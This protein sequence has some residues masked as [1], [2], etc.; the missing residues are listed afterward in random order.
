MRKSHLF[1]ATA[2]GLVMGLAAG[3]VQAETVINTATTTA[4]KTSTA[5]ST[6]TAD[7]I[8]LDTGGTITLKTAGARAI[9]VD[10]NNKVNVVGAI[11][12]SSSGDDATGIY[13][14]GGR[15][16]GLTLS[17]KITVT[18]DY[19][20]TDTDSPADGITDGPFAKG[21]R[22]YGIR[23]VGTTPFVGNVSLASGS[24]IQVEGNNSYGVRFE[25]ALTGNFNSDS[26]VTVVGTN[27][28]AYSFEGGVTGNIVI[29][30]AT[31]V[32]GE[33]ATALNLGSNLTGALI[34]DGSIAG[35]GYR[36]TTVADKTT[37][38]KLQAEDKLQAGPLVNISGNVTKGILLQSTIANTDSTKPAA[39]QNNDEDG[40]GVLD[41]DDGA[42]SLSQYGGA[43]ALKVGSA[44]QDITINA[45]SIASTATD[46]YKNQTFG[47]VVRGNIASS[48]VFEGVVAKAIETG[49]LGRTVTFE[50]G[51]LVN[52]TVSA[53]SYLAGVRT[54]NLLSGT[55]ANK[56][57]VGGTVRAAN[58]STKNETGYAVYIA[59]GA[60][61][62]EINVSGTVSA[63]ATGSKSNAT[64]IFD[65]SNTLVRLT[66]TGSISATLT[67]TDDDGDGVVDATSNRAV[68]IDLS[69]NTA[70]VTLTQTNLKPDDATAV[71]PVIT[72]DIRLGS[73]NDA[74]NINGGFVVGN[75]DFGAG[76]NSLSITT[77]GIVAGKMT[78]AG[79]VSIDIV[80]GA[81]NLDAG[82]KL[83]ATTVNV[84]KDGVLR[85][86]PD[87]ANPTTPIIVASGA[88]VFDTGAKV[89]IGMSSIVKPTTRYTLITASNITLG[90]LDTASLDSNIP[91]LYK[92][93]LST[94]TG[95][96]ALYADVRLRT[97]SET[98]LSPN[99]FAAF[100]A[101]LT[102]A[103]GNTGATRAL[104]DPTSADGFNKAYLSFLPDYSGETLLTLSKSND[105][106]SR[107]MASQSI[108]P[109][110]GVNQYWAQEYG[111]Q[112]N[113]DRGEATGFDST[114]FAFAGGVER[115]ITSTQAAGLYLAYTAA[116][117]KGTLGAPDEDLSSTD[118]S[119]GLYWRMDTGSG[120]KSWVR[121][122]VGYAHFDSKRQILEPS[123]IASSTAKWKGVSYSGSVGA[124]YS[125]DAGWLSLTPMVSADYY[126]LKEDAH[127]E[128]G[129]GTAFDL[130]VDE[131][132]GHIFSGTA[133]LNIGRSNKTALF[134][135]EV[136]VG[137]R[138]N[139][140][141]EIADT[142][143]RFGTATPFTLKGGDIKGGAPIAGVRIAASN[144]YSYFGI[145]AEYEKYDAYDNVSLSLRA[146]FQF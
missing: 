15:T 132:T 35:T 40:N 51:I 71:A 95:N 105:G 98:T 62:P 19:T 137:Y 54:V 72:G 28:R 37:L 123:F 112:I 26:T 85:F 3:A 114:G 64:A 5:T 122:G 1:N 102:A 74:V 10:S 142:V 135:P 145:E 79:T 130:S 84:R 110:A 17:G 88:A 53:T 8:K 67:R 47:L 119:V 59:S 45:I 99:E 144:E 4:V 146:R 43:A 97:Q 76:S 42:A 60:Q 70:G 41:T 78:G 69:G 81:L 101:V 9:T 21:E 125:V 49:G 82:S 31:T 27:A 24:A 143:A 107:T 61:V 29:G 48:G 73:G 83:N 131:R 141:A 39:E 66:N 126:G 136:W 134:R 77:N 108:I 106:L 127:T 86:V 139:F 20:P 100:D 121:G 36:L 56:F 104:L 75:I 65:G 109:Q 113:R 23:S 96:T 128:T 140:S 124:S 120:L 6:G 55:I 63:A 30:G 93:A 92:A 138:N 94:N 50:N 46:T 68:A 57:N 16:S 111:Y 133:L 44:T 129:G 118:L 14:D 116:N 32:Q 38:D 80:K 18:D 13:I 2:I 91:Y 90:T 103:Q 22:R 115:G 52:G 11:D 34:L 89:Q 25:N 117:P 87:T 7:D 33:N 12:M 58:S